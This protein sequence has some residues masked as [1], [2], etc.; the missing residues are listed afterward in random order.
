MNAIIERGFVLA[1]CRKSD[2]GLP[3]IEVDAIRLVENLGVAGDYHSGEFVRHRY[4]AKKDPTKPNLRQVLLVDTGMHA[5]I[6]ARGIVIGPGMLG[7]NV[8]LEGIRVMGLP[9]GTRLELGEALLQ[10]TEV[11]NPCYQLNEI[12]PRLLKAVAYKSNGQVYRNAGM[13]GRILSGGWV[14]PGDRVVVRI[15]ADQA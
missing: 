2:P 4:L 9:I 8:L 5:D 13:M 12:D 1:V 15:D 3:K 10:L 11:R 7:E 14:R 6:S